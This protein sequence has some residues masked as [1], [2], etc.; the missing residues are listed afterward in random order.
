MYNL[1]QNGRNGSNKVLTPTLAR[2]RPRYLRTDWTRN[3][4]IWFVGGHW[5]GLQNHKR[6]FENF[7]IWSNDLLFIISSKYVCSFLDF[8]LFM[9]EISETNNIQQKITHNLSTVVFDD[10]PNKP[11]G[12][13]QQQQGKGGRWR[14]HRVSRRRSGPGIRISHGTS[15]K[16]RV[17]GQHQHISYKE[18]CASTWLCWGN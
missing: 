17:G 18:K 1:G 6:N 16:I 13:K 12:R 7:M 11:I 14:D 5:R 9:N 8:Y 4:E 3:T 2:L 10:R 15:R